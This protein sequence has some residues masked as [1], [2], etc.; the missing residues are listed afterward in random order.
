MRIKEKIIP[1]VIV[2]LI[3]SVL[4]FFAIWNISTMQYSQN[5]ICPIAALSGNS[6]P[7]VSNSAAFAWH[8]ISALQALTQ[9][10]VNLDWLLLV[11]PGLFLAVLLIITSE[12]DIKT[13]NQKNFQAIYKLLHKS[14]PLPKRRFLSWLTLH[15]KLNP[16]AP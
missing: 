12:R 10:V 4:G 15:N 13:D 9:S 14:T 5:H 11:F 16:H 3:I 8:H 6:C 7:P 1:T 2:I